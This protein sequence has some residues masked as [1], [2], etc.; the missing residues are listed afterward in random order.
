MSLGSLDPSAK[1]TVHYRVALPPDD[2]KPVRLNSVVPWDLYISHWSFSGTLPGGSSDLTAVGSMI[3]GPG[4]SKE[5]F[6]NNQHMAIVDIPAHIMALDLMGLDPARC[7]G[8]EPKPGTPPSWWDMG[9]FV[10]KDAPTKEQVKLA[11]ERFRKWAKRKVVE[12]DSV[13]AQTKNVAAVDSLAK[14]CAQI[15][16]VER[17]WSKDVIEGS[18]DI[19]CPACAELIKPK[20]QICRHCGSKLWNVDGTLR[21]DRGEARPVQGGSAEVVDMTKPRRP[22]PSPI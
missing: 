19:E 20:A 12:G 17:E 21:W 7:D 13:Y 8:L 15:L 14:K 9:V 22:G 11:A 10:S 2:L 1:P 18:Q 3:V 16:R 6:G 4:L 5:D